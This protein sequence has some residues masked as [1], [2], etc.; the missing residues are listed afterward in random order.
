MSL[1]NTVLTLGNKVVLF[2]FSVSV[3]L[4]K[5]ILPVLLV[6]IIIFKSW[7]GRCYSGSFVFCVFVSVC[8]CIYIYIFVCVCLCARQSA[9]F[10]LCLRVA[11]EEY[12]FSVFGSVN[13]SAEIVPFLGAAGTTEK[14]PQGVLFQ[15]FWFSKSVSWNCPISGSSW[16]YRKSSTRSIIWVF[17]SRQGVLFQCFGV[18]R[19]S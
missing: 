14:A 18:S 3:L 4:Q 13:Q 7:F 8:L 17:W 1:C 6:R 12:Y 19:S 15:C 9:R 11:R 16:H 10:V 2:Y 5:N